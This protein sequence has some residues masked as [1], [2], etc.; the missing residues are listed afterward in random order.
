MLITS[1]NNKGLNDILMIQLAKCSIDNQITERKG[2]ITKIVSKDNGDTVG[3]NFFE[4]S[5]LLDL[6][7]NGPVTLSEQEVDTLNQQIKQNGWSDELV[8]DP[9]PKFVVGHV[10]ECKPMADSDHLNITQTEIDNGEVVQIVCGAANIAENQKVVVAKPGA[11]MPDGLVI[12]PGELRGTKSSGMICSAKELNLDQV[13][14]G[15]LVL[16]ETEE[17]GS[18]FELNR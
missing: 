8:A 1:Y 5:E 15:I 9:S 11:I 2:N 18:R 7:N 6:K 4:V 17:T 10:K 16:D 13:S 12:W 3:F 14:I